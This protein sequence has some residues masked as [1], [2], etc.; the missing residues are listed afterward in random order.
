MKGYWGSGGIVPRILLPRHRWR[1][2]VSFTPWPPYPQEKNLCYPLDRR[3]GRR[4][5]RSGC[6]GEEKNSQS[7]PEL[8]HPIIQPVAQRCDTELSHVPL[9]SD[10][11][12]CNLFRSC[13]LLYQI[14]RERQDISPK[15]TSYLLRNSIIHVCV[16]ACARAQ[17]VCYFY[18]D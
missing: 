17:E 9:N 10:D 11:I 8:K 12:N 2:V 4:Q 15:Y 3:L 14:A 16:C 6:G 13:T 5:S 1:W 7:L 18:S